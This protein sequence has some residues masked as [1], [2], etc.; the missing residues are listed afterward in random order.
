MRFE[1]ARLFAARTRP[2]AVEPKAGRRTG[3]FSAGSR[4]DL[5]LKEEMGASR[6]LSVRAERAE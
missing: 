2:S 1:A 3:A 5:P 6:A 4:Q